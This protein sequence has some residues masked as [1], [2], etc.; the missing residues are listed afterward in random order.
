MAIKNNHAYLIVFPVAD[1]IVAVEGIQAW[2]T[3]IVV[4]SEDN[5]SAWRHMFEVKCI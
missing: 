2:N 3:L 1:F 4:T 5:A